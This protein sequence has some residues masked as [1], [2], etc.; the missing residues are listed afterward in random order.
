MKGC[1]GLLVCVFSGLFGLLGCTAKKMPEGDLVR[2]EFSRHGT[3][4][5]PEYKGIV[6]QDSTGVFVIRAM[7]EAFLYLPYMRKNNSTMLADLSMLR[8]F[9]GKKQKNDIKRKYLAPAIREAKLSRSYRASDEFLLNDF[10]AI[11]LPALLRYVD[12]NAMAFSIEDRL[13]FLDYRLV[14]FCMQLPMNAKIDRGWSKAIMR[15]TLDMPESV[16][17]RR[18]KIGF[19]TPE[20]EW[21]RSHGKE[22]R[23][24]FEKEDFRAERFIDR[25]AILAD[26]DSLLEHDSI[27]L[28]RYLCL[29][30]WMEIFDVKAA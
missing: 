5:G 27:G 16:R 19:Y 12:R 28:F 26:W 22:Y 17:G 29:E 9:L 4:A 10:R 24:V 11:V 18:D 6:E 20:S 1:R 21:I 25:Q 8:Q 14:E 13:P 30:K 3:M 15:R 2:V 7:R 23:A